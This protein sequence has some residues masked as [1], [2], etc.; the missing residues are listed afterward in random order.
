MNQLVLEPLY[1]WHYNPNILTETEFKT[2]T[3][4]W[5]I[6]LTNYRFLP[7]SRSHM[8][9]AFIFPRHLQTIAREHLK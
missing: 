7:I 2:V 9:C 8:Q 1:A 4:R 6:E 3:N 5:I